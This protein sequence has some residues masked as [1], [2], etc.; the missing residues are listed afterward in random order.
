MTGHSGQASDFVATPRPPLGAARRRLLIAGVR[1]LGVPCVRLLEHLGMWPDVLGQRVRAS[2]GDFGDYLPDAHDVIVCSWFKS[3]TNWTLQTALQ[4]AHRGRAEFASIHDVVPW[5]DAPGRMRDAVIPLDDPSPVER[6]PTG[7]RI[8][9]THLASH[10]VPFTTEARYIAVVRDPKDV[11]V[12][13]YHFLRAIAWGPLAPSVSRWVDY[14]LSPSFHVGNWA[15]H[16]A[17]YW[18]MRDRSNV[19][20]LTFEDMKRDGRAAVMRIAEFMGVD[21]APEELE[22]VVMRSG[23][24]WMKA[25]G[26][27]FDAG[28]PAPW[29]ATGGY[30]IRHGRQGGAAELL[31][32]AERTRI[33]EHC[34]AELRHLGCDFPY[35]RAFG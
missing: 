8:I 1:T 18:A 15:R 26:G 19:L 28:A 21:L 33:D 4:T 13:G 9:K 27:Q 30:M 22:A 10:E 31:G 12:S 35:E 3:G 2:M 25:H 23:F 16:L 32:A 14:F 29:A 24:D 11:C 17:G 7:L 5:P 20:F 34:R 6:S